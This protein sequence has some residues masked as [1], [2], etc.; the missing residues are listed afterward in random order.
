MPVKLKFNYKF[1]QSNIARS[2][3]A[4]R[5]DRAPIDELRIGY[6]CN[7]RPDPNEM[8]DD[9]FWAPVTCLRLSIVIGW[10]FALCLFQ[11]VVVGSWPKRFESGI[12]R[13]RTAMY[14]AWLD[15]EGRGSKRSS[16]GFNSNF[17]FKSKVLMYSEVRR[18]SDAMFL[19]HE[20]SRVRTNRDSY[21]RRTKAWRA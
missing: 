1:K 7:K 2:E 4:P 19:R 15:T 5:T 16:S 17:N 10:N 14:Q 11:D 9:V 21:L 3:Q 13:R 20:L 8:R 6:Y 12:E 18:R